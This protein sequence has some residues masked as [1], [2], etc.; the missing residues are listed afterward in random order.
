MSAPLAFFSPL[1]LF[2]P[3]SK[4]DLAN[5]LIQPPQYPADLAQ[6]L[7]DLYFSKINIYLP[8]L[9]RPTFEKSVAEGLH[10]T[11][12]LFASTYVLVCAV[13]ARFS[14]D[15][16]VFNPDLYHPPGSTLFNQ[17]QIPKKSLPSLYEL[18]FHCVRVFCRLRSP[19]T[20]FFFTAFRSF[21][22]GLFSGA[23]MF[24]LGE[25][26]DTFSS[27]CWGASKKS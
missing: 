24:D 9:H 22:A 20:W 26:R 15:P 17:I 12:G 13:G 4:R 16:R 11:D 5:L 19:I 7:V 27:G 25:G 2:E 1:V 14:D 23:I 10:H 18:H 8:L 3:L 6:T 21:F